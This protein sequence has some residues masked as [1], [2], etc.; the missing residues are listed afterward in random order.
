M[1]RAELAANP[2][3]ETVIRPPSGGVV[4]LT[5]AVGF[6][7]YGAAPDGVPTAIAEMS[8]EMSRAMMARIRTAALLPTGMAFSLL[9]RLPGATAGAGRRSM[10][11]ETTQTTPAEGRN[12][13]TQHDLSF[14]G[15]GGSL[16]SVTSAGSWQV[17]KP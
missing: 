14:S 10:F 8:A 5:F 13:T 11:P 3:P 1:V 2:P 4:V 7:T 17:N 9:Q 16:K 12:V 6:V 15:A